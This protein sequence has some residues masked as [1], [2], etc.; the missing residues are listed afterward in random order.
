MPNLT[1]G[2][3]NNKNFEDNW[4]LV[5][6]YLYSRNDDALMETILR[7]FPHEIETERLLIRPPQPG[8]GL[9]LSTAVAASLEELRAWMP[10]AMVE[11]SAEISEAYARRGYARFISREDL[12]LMVLHKTNGAIIGGSGLHRID[13]DVPRFEI[14]YWLQTSYTGQGYMTEAVTAISDF[15]FTVL[16]AKRV[17]IRCDALNKR[18]AAVAR[19]VGYTLE[20]TLHR[21]SRHHVSHTLRDTLIFVRTVNDE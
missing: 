20:A 14:G 15:A 17:E 5:F 11:P 13:W 21:E 12:P 3:G 18:S 16:G 7:D 1:G 2:V 8:D 19:R 4:W 6:F 9:A 10:W